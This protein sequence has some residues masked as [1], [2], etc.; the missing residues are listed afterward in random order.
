MNARLPVLSRG[1]H[2]TPSQGQCL[3]EL[4]SELSGEVW[5]DRPAAVHPVLASVARCVNDESTADGRQRL[6]PFAAQMIGTDQAKEPVSVA[7]V[8]HCRT[9]ALRRPVHELTGWDRLA[10]PSLAYRFC[11]APLAAAGATRTVAAAAGAQKDD[12]LHHL[13]ADCVA[14]CHGHDP[15]TTNWWTEWGE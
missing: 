7:L 13:L 8:T 1:R 15:T 9:V 6:I 4:V 14:I 3:L 10:A 2:P 5:S 12:V 11:V